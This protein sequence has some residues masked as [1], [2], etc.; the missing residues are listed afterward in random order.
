MF[1]D[2]IIIVT[3][4]RE[5]RRPD[6]VHLIL[7]SYMPRLV[8]EGNC[9]TGADLHA[10]M[11]L[12][13]MGLPTRSYTADWKRYGTRAGHIRNGIMLH[14]WRKFPNV[15]VCAFPLTQGDGTQ[16]CMAQALALGMIVENYGEAA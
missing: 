10:R 13:K 2:V 9:P 1:S 4:S 7:E 15:R 11:W 6:R 5:W 16:D 12:G 3:G 8:I 14:D